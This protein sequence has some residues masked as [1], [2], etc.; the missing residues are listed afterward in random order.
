MKQIPQ[1]K[2]KSADG[3]TR[4]EIGSPGNAGNESG[5]ERKSHYYDRDKQHA[6]DHP[7]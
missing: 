7:G 5:W 6:A 4:S 3:L 2:P 1:F